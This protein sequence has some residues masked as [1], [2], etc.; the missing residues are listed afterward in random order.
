MRAHARHRSGAVAEMTAGLSES[1]STIF[2]IMLEQPAEYERLLHGYFLL[3]GERR[4]WW[5]R[6]SEADD[7]R[8]TRCVASAVRSIAKRSKVDPA[9][10]ADALDV[11]DALPGCRRRIIRMAREQLARER[12]FDVSRAA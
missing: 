4:L 9:W 11:E 7:P 1:E 10:L 5:Q 6:C 2:T 8:W 3:L 12:L